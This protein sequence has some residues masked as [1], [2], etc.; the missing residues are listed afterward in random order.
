MDKLICNKPFKLN[1]KAGM[2]QFVV[3]EEVTGDDAKHW[4]AKAHCKATKAEV[5]ESQNRDPVADALATK[6]LLAELSKDG[7][8]P[9]MKDV[10]KALREAKLPELENAEARDKILATLEPVKAPESTGDNTADTTA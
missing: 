6:A 2:R 3:G 9:N 1:T 7:K 10:Q 5:D 4:Y 8:V